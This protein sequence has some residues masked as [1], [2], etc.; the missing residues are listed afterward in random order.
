MASGLLARDPRERV[1]RPAAL[2]SCVAMASCIGLAFVHGRPWELRA[3]VLEA[4]ALPD[5]PVTLPVP[6]GLAMAREDDEVVFGSTRDALVVSC[7]VADADEPVADA[8]ADLE[9][10]VR[11]WTAERLAAG[12]EREAPASLVTVG[13]RPAAH[14]ALR[15]PS[16]ARRELW[17]FVEEGIRLRVDTVLD[18]D[19]PDA[20]RLVPARIAAGVVFT[21]PPASTAPAPSSPPSPR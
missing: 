6:R 17:Q 12:V 11:A 5:A 3:P 2:L 7:A 16:G 18:D 21:A 8:A 14:V 10:T 9:Q 1:W 19:A 13:G 4:R 15:Y 20:W